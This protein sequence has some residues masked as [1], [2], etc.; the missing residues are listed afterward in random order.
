VSGVPWP[1]LAALATI[2]VVGVALMAN[3]LVHG[4]PKLP[5]RPPPA[6]TGGPPRI[7]EILQTTARSRGF[8]VSPEWMA[9]VGA[10][11]KAGAFTRDT[12]IDFLEVEIAAAELAHITATIEHRQAEIR[13]LRQKRRNLL[14]EIEAHA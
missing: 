10:R 13:G 12:T 2:L 3:V 5:V 1:Y 8:E 14:A 11:A 6:K 9:D 4:S 7:E